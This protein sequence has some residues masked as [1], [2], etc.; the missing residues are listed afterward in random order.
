MRTGWL[1]FFVAALCSASVGCLS[2][3]GRTV[4]CEHRGMDEAR[5]VRLEQRLKTLEQR[6]GIQPESQQVIVA[7]SL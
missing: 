4:N 1:L 5:I 7:P 6:A 2:I 3:G